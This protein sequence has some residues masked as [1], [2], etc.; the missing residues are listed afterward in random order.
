MREVMMVDLSLCFSS[1]EFDE[2]ILFLLN[3]EY[4]KVLLSSFEIEF[5]LFLLVL[6]SDKRSVLFGPYFDFDRLILRSL[7]MLRDEL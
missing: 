4:L 3:F 7:W 6:L 5:S 2:Y 1:L